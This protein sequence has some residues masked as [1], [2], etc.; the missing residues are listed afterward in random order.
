MSC[1]NSI[2]INIDTDLFENYF[3]IYYPNVFTPNGDGENDLF[4]V[5]VPGRIN[6]CTELIIYNRFGEIQ[7]ISTGNNLK[8][9]GRNNVGVELPNGTYFYTLNVK[10]GFF[11][12]NDRLLKLK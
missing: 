10:N 9:D 5:E 1:T 4:I 3:D 2:D 8:W 12:H 6:E 11:M 7:F